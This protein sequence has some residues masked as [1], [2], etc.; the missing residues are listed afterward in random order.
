MSYPFLSPA[1]INLDFKILGRREDGY[2]LIRSEMVAINLFDELEVALSPTNCLLS[3]QPL[4]FDFNTS[5]FFK[6]YTQVKRKIPD[7]PCFQIKI[8]KSIPIGAGLGGGSSNAATFIFAIRQL[9]NLDWTDNEMIEIAKGIGADV[10]FFFSY[11]RA[12]AEGIG[13]EITPL[14][15]LGKKNFTLL[16]DAIS[17][18]TPL[19]Y[20]HVDLEQLDETARNQLEKFAAIAYPAYAQTLKEWKHLFGEVTMTGSGSAAFVEGIIPFKLY[21]IR[22]F[23]S[24]TIERRPNEWYHPC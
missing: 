3:L 16:F 1:K 22:G 21:G 2:H 15:L 10:P 12:L 4:P 13:T 5:I 19:V 14:P 17:I 8:K 7:L 20:R 18:A 6:A 23:H 11:G 9:L 24:H